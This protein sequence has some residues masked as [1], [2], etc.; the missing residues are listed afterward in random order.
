[1]SF[2]S[3]A[4]YTAQLQ[5]S[6]AAF[7]FMMNSSLLY[8]VL[9]GEIVLAG[10][11][12]FVP[13][14]S[15]SLLLWWLLEIAVFCLIAY[16]CYL[17]SF[18]PARMWGET[19]KGT[20]DLYR[21]DLLKQLGYNT[22]P[23]N[24]DEERALWRRISAQMA[25]GDGP[26]GPRAEYSRAK[27]SDVAPS[28]TQVKS[29]SSLEDLEITRGVHRSRA[30]LYTTIHIRVRHKR[31]DGA[32]A[33]NVE[34]VESLPVG[35]DYVWSSAQIPDGTVEV[36]GMNPYHFSVGTIAAG[37]DVTLTYGVLR[38]TSHDA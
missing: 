30:D 29:S 26:E 36:S 32:A 9:V 5:E 16:G 28:A 4:N 33:E 2:R 3:D 34:I 35:D 8:L 12:W 19:F 21:L 15:V 27:P 11:L 24:R 13:M 37:R 31:P 6:K 22:V 17:A 10:I 20:F 7:D 23:G 25:L 1:M 18:K 14:S 38:G